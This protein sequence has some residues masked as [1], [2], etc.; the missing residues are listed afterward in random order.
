MAATSWYQKLQGSD[1][2]IA[3]AAGL[4]ISGAAVLAAATAPE[5]AVALGAV[6]LLSLGLT[7]LAT[8]PEVSTWASVT[9]Q[10]KGSCSR[11]F[12]WIA[13]FMSMVSLLGPEVANLY[14]PMISTAGSLLLRMKETE[15]AAKLALYC[16]A[17]AGLSGLVYGL[18]GLLAAPL[19][20]AGGMYLASSGASFAVGLA[21]MHAISFGSLAA[22]TIACLKSI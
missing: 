22:Y 20:L 14:H 1:A 18:S 2:L 8:T 17:G 4:Y 11:S 12:R 15:T 3:T 21:F 9:S 13:R 5:I 16:A 10:N 19:L 6:A 7:L